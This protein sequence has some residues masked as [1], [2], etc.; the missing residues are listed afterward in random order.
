MKKMVHGTECT[1]HGKSVHPLTPVPCAMRLEPLLHYSTIP[2]FH[3]S[4]CLLLSPVYLYSVSFVCPTVERPWPGQKI[5]SAEHDEK[6]L[7]VHIMLITP[8]MGQIVPQIQVSLRVEIRSVIFKTPEEC[9][10]FADF[11]GEVDSQG[12]SQ[13]AS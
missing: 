11:K 2:T 3:Y 5:L 4:P 1:V 8:R 9:D 7:A 13:E 12:P 6:S 10:L